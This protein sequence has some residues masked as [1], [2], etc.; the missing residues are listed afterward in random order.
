[1][2][3]PG[4]FSDSLSTPQPE[5]V[6]RAAI[7]YRPSAS[8]L[9]RASGFMSDYDYTL[10]PYVG[11]AFGCTYCY[12]AS[13]VRTL[14]QRDH[15]GEWV[16]VKENALAKLRN[17][18]TDL[19]DKTIYMSSVTDPYQ[20]VERRLGLVRDLLAILAERGARL[21]V[22]TRSPLVTRDL[23]LYARFT[24][25][26]I[27]MTVTTDSERVRRIFEPQCPPN[28][29]RLNAIAAVCRANIPCS[30]TLTPLLPVEDV[31][32]FATALC[33]TEVD[34]FVVQPF[35]AERGRFVAG[36]REPAL[37][38]IRDLGWDHVAY[39]RTVDRLRAV[40][41]HLAEGR[42]GFRPQ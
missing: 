3:E 17:M 6:G 13:F 12:A 7:S 14:D 35:H 28:A 30:I 24:H 19:R 42:A 26:R 27:N 11:C 31:D 37:A 18:R 21:V 41:P 33:A 2:R 10:N 36:T 22:Q 23:D 39:R 38:L 34:D 8:I 25:V 40:L 20:L 1:M 5:R 16:E 9:T 32:A 4:P 29:A 15:W